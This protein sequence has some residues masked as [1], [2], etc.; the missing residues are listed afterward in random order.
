ML[1]KLQ[2]MSTDHIISSSDRDKTLARPL[3]GVGEH[4]NQRHL[5]LSRTILVSGAMRQNHNRLHQLPAGPMPNMPGGQIAPLPGNSYGGP[6]PGPPQAAAAPA[7]PSRVLMLN[8]LLTAT[9][10]WDD[11]ERQEVK[12]LPDFDLFQAFESFCAP[13]SCKASYVCA[14]VPQGLLPAIGPRMCSGTHLFM[15]LH[16]L[17]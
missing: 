15:F 10:I 1:L 13:H 17:H 6:L 4:V 2:S 5:E 11:Q 8:N 12:H 16:C 3:D 14:H 7:G 9:T